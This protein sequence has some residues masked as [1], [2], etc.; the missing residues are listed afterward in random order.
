VVFRGQAKHHVGRKQARQVATMFAS[1]VRQFAAQ[2][3]AVVVLS[4]HTVP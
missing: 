3:M 4:Y 1:I 2:Q